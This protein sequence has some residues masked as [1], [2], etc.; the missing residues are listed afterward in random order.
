M[1]A[2]LLLAIEDELLYLFFNS[3]EQLLPP[4]LRVCFSWT[5][6]ATYMNRYT[7]CNTALFEVAIG[8]RVSKPRPIYR[9]LPLEIWEIEVE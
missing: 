1:C 7:N 3:L 2:L 9:S 6:Y 4:V 5:D 8:D